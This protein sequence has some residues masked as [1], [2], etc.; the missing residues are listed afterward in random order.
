[1]KLIRFGELR[2]E[3]PG[4]LTGN[5]L[6]KD[7]S[8][9]FSDWDSDF[10][11]GNGLRR[12][13]E[14]LRL[15]GD[16]LP[17]VPDAVRWGSPIPRPGKVICI[18]LNYSD[19]AAETGAPIPTEPILFMK[20]ANTVVGPFDDIEIPRGSTKTDWE[21]ELGV[22]IGHTAR[23]LRDAAQARDH[24]AGYVLTHDVSERAFQ[25]E[26]G[27]QWTKG[28]SCDTFNPLGPFLLTADV[29]PIPG[30][31]AMHLDVNGQRRQTGNTSTMIFDVFTLVHYIS[32]FMTLEPGDL[33]STGTP[34][35]VGLGM[36]PPQYLKP[37]DIIE[38]EIE[39]LGSQRQRC[40]TAP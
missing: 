26:R 18:G 19:H 7:L 5:G 37:G 25:L 8:A 33:I 10:L 11:A 3:R 22:V 4:V 23:Y 27:G 30:K 38:L 15:H 16:K 36:K 9:H 31:L 21:V 17:S 12:L 1:M 39:Q 6:R 28:K 32:Q 35:G 13:E 34:P 14:I 2:K 29:L 20:A 24:I 40:I